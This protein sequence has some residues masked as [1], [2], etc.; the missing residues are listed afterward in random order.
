M[1]LV[2]SE[3]SDIVRDQMTK[4]RTILEHA[5]PSSCKPC[6]S[7]KRGYAFDSIHLDTYNRFAEKVCDSFCF[8]HVLSADQYL[9]SG[10]WVSR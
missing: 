5:D 2:F 9:L 3:A 6:R 8:T 10:R 1:G 4:L 7:D